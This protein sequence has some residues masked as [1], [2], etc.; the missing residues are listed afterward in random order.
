[1][2]TKKNATIKVKGKINTKKIGKYKVKF[3]VKDSIGNT[4]S[5]TITFSVVDTKKPVITGA[6]I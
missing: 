1:M 6:K 4:K 5:K 3:T 2:L